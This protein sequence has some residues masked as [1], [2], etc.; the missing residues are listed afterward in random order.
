MGR[1]ALGENGGRRAPSGGHQQ[2]E[3]DH[4]SPGVVGSVALAGPEVEE[5]PT[6]RPDPHVEFH[7]P[8]PEFSGYAQLIDMIRE[9]QE[10]Q[11]YI[12]DEKRAWQALA[13]S[14]ERVQCFFLDY[15]QDTGYVAPDSW[16]ARRETLEYCWRQF[17]KDVG[18]FA[19][20]TGFDEDSWADLVDVNDV[21]DVPGAFWQE[22]MAAGTLKWTICML[23]SYS[24]LLETSYIEET[25]CDSALPGVRGW[26]ESWR[27]NNFL[28]PG[29][30]VSK[31]TLTTGSYVVGRMCGLPSTVVADTAGSLGDAPPAQASFT[32]GSLEIHLDPEFLLPMGEFADGWMSAAHQLYWAKKEAGV[33]PGAGAASVEDQIF[34]AGALA[35]APV[36]ELAFILMHEFAHVGTGSHCEEQCCQARLSAQWYASVA[37]RNGVVGGPFMNDPDGL[38]RDGAASPPS[39]EVTFRTVCDD[40]LSTEVVAVVQLARPGVP[41]GY[42]DWSMTTT[43]PANC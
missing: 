3:A 35:L 42:G 26:I 15:Y 14:R 10:E 37:S 36:V 30:Y 24:C 23:V 32:S 19:A 2:F 12:R 21:T 29:L 20:K 16:E 41:A 27:L 40:A 7:F 22:G 17:V 6:D 43:R 25:G 8:D 1:A 4:L 9:R 39:G 11:K 5:G 18:A 34:R 38:G 31:S 13:G 28:S 33:T